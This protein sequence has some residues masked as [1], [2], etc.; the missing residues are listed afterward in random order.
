MQFFNPEYFAGNIPV[1]IT[2]VDKDG[3]VFCG[4]FDRSQVQ[5]NVDIHEQ[6]IWR[7]RKTR[8]VEE[9]GCKRIQTFYPE[10][11]TA[12]NF[13]WNKLQDYSYRYKRN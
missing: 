8:I 5:P 3:N 2:I 6:P 13:E 11:S 1:D 9:D 12:F 10:G 7:I 4:D